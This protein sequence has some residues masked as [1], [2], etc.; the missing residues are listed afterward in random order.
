M[1]DVENPITTHSGQIILDG[2]VLDRL[3]YLESLVTHKSERFPYKDTSKLKKLFDREWEK[4]NP[5]FDIYFM[6]VDGLSSWGRRA[7]K[8]SPEE[9]ERVQETLE[10]N[11]FEKH[12]EYKF[13][14]E[15]IDEQDDFKDLK[16]YMEKNEFLRLN[17]LSILEDLRNLKSK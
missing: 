12:P 8:W 7:L 2:P 15:I 13:L 3:L 17:M 4:L 9:M 10:K 6:D 11:F 16:K 5:R 1:D 14:E